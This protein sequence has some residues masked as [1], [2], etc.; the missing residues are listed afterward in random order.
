MAS[1]RPSPWMLNQ[2]NGYGG[3]FHL[4]FIAKKAQTALL[5]NKDV[6]GHTA[7]T[8]IFRQ[9]L[10]NSANKGNIGVPVT[11]CITSRHHGYGLNT[12]VPQGPVCWTLHLQVVMLFWEVT[13]LEEAGHW[14]CGFEGQ[15]WSPEPPPLCFLS[16]MRWITSSSTYY[17][18]HNVQLKHT[19]SET[20]GH[21]LMYK[22]SLTPSLASFKA[23]SNLI[24]TH[25]VKW[26]WKGEYRFVS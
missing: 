6:Q 17:S 11:I 5:L 20:H 12:D 25:G 23:I 3:V 21:K 10:P 22:S 14:R 13:L 16:T 9:R 26:I 4:D 2:N 8:N 24:R 15:T 18:C 1:I 7:L 19:D